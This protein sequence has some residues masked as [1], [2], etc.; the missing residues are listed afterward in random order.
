MTLKSMS[1]WHVYYFKLKA[2]KAQQSQEELFTFPLTAQKILD[3]GLKP[4]R[5][6]L[7]EITFYTRKTYL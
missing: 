6:L 7:V 5:E 3:R 1:L 4:G 2:I